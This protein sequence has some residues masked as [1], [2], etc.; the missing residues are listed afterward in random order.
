MKMEKI[1][2]VQNFTMY[3]R[4]WRPYIFYYADIPNKI[5]GRIQD[6]PQ[7]GDANPPS[8]HPHMVLPNFPK[9]SMKLRKF[10]GL[11]GGGRVAS[12]GPPLRSKIQKK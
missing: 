10:W 1:G 2:P 4:H 9:Y 7:E 11:G 6:S 12:L 3:I 8:G 5:Q